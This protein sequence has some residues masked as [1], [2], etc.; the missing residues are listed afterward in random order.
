M[1]I[2]TDTLL[3][4]GYYIRIYWGFFLNKTRF[5]IISSKVHEFAAM[6]IHYKVVFKKK[7]NNLK[8]IFDN[9]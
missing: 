1:D 5:K 3:C 9:M 6:C 8:S 2:Y 7:Y 4:V